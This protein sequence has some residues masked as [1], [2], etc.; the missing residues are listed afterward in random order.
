MTKG[1]RELYSSV[2]WGVEV[3]GGGDRSQRSGCAGRVPELI[4]HDPGLRLA[5][6]GQ[7]GAVPGLRAAQ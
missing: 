2:I 5:D 3:E 7:C 6:G 1:E 4:G